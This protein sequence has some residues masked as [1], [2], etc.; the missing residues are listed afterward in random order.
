MNSK[1]AINETTRL[2]TDIMSEGLIVINEEGIIEIYNK[3]AME[4]FRINLDIKNSHEAGK[5]NK[6][7]IVI[8]CNNSLGEDDGDLDLRTLKLIGLDNY[9]L[10]KKDAFISIS[11]YYNK[12][13]KS[14]V[15]NL[16]ED[17]KDNCLILNSKKIPDLDIQCKI[18][19][20]DKFVNIKI[21]NTDYYMDYINSIGHI[22]IVDSESKEVK[23]FQ[24]YGYTA[25]GECIKEILEGKEYLSKGKKN[26]EFE[27]LGKHIN[28]IHQSNYIIKDTLDI[29]KGLADEKYNK[30]ELINGIPTL[31]SILKVKIGDKVKG[32]ALKVEDK[33]DIETITKE[34]DSAIRR[35]NLVGKELKKE[36][37]VNKAFSDFVGESSEIMH[38]KK[39]ALKASQT[40]S[41]I[42]LLGK[43]GTGKSVLARL[44]HNNSNLKANNF[45]EINCAA[46]PSELLESELFG[47]VAGAF[48]GAQQKGKKGLLEVANNGSVFLDEIGDMPMSSQAKLLRVIQEGV[49]FPVGGIEAKTVKTRIIA[50]TNKNLEKEILEGRFREDLFYRINVFPIYIPALKERKEDIYDLIK[51]ILKKFAEDSNLGKI[52]ISSEATN[53]LLKYDWPGNVRELENILERAINLSEGSLILSKHI[54]IDTLVEDLSFKTFS[55][56]IKEEERKHIKNT[57]NICFGDTQKAIEIL[58]MSKSNFYKKLKEYNIEYKKN[59]I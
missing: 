21:N 20:I 30:F 9:D 15:K 54:K 3:K 14:I 11:K 5:I 51:L 2:F 26:E 10:E 31:C 32:A 29:A 6:D 41:N 1:L 25:R 40:S 50:A 37:Y 36:E 13:F 19:F 47:Y 42:L 38:V 39:L 24:H 43:S 35:L 27:V 57:L 7:D 16:K 44:I 34:R 48:T 53:K 28:A 33:T 59:Y 17:Y 4:I 8:I 23:F 22:V 58:D 46:I 18:N 12:S 49:F 45:V 56:H 52:D 55:E